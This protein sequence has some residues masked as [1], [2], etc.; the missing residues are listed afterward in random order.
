M[1]PMLAG[2]MFPYCVVKAGVLADVTGDGPEILEVEDQ[3]A[4]F[5]GDAEDQVQ[6][7]GLGVVELEQPG[8]KQ[9]SHFRD[10]GPQRMPQFPKD[11]PKGDGK[12]GGGE[13]GESERHGAFADLG[14]LS[15]GLA[16]SGQVAFDVGQEHGHAQGTESFGESLERD[17]LSGAGGAG[18]QAVAIGQGRQQFEAMRTGL[19]D[20]DR[21]WHGMGVSDFVAA[22]KCGFRSGLAMSAP[23]RS[24]QRSFTTETQRRGGDSIWKAGRPEE[25]GGKVGG[26]AGEPAA[27]F[28]AED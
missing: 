2:E 7:A 17:G 11:I 22:K 16:D 9:R 8:E 13:V 12:A 28:L 19:G 20:V 24:E 6:D 4:V 21:T 5:V 27:L 26:G 3:Q 25:A 10:G 1:A 18:N 14:I 23:T 15:T